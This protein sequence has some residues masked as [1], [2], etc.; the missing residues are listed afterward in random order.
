MKYY[1][2]GSYLVGETPSTQDIKSFIVKDYENVNVL[3]LAGVFLVVMMSFKSAV[4]PDP[5]HHPDR[6]GDL[7]Q[8][9]DAV[10]PGR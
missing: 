3:S 5:R 8:H 9:G 1:P 6:G 2:D 10:F 7:H 4:M